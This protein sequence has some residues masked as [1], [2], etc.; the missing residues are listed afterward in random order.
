MKLFTVGPTQMR[1]EIMEVGG[2]MV[3]Y[4]RTQEFSNL[5]L[6]SDRLVQKFMHAP[7]GS[8]GIYLTASGTGAMEAVIMNCLTKEDKVLVIDG[9]TFG[10][11]FA[12]LC[13]I[14]EIPYECVHLKADEQLTEDKLAPFDNIG[15]TALLV[16]IDETS[17]GQLYD[18]NMLANFCRRNHCYF[19]VDA[20]SSY[21]IDPFNMEKNGIDVVVVSSQ[22]GMCIAPGLS[23]VMLS[24]RIIEERVKKSKVQNLYFNFKEYLKNFQR[25]QTPFTPCVGICLE[26]NRALHLIDEEGETDFLNRIGEVAKDFRK[27]VQVLPVKIPKFPLSNAV[28][29]IIFDKPIAKKVFEVLKDQY[30][31]FVNPTGG[32]RENYV[33]RVAHIGDTTVEDNKMLIQVMDN[34]IKSILEEEE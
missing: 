8:K 10:H 3:P 29:P 20:I 34:V 33:L 17:T 28:T 31:I 27:R 13:A 30:D 1:K 15:F 11:R 14:H 9:G 6:D 24:P 4:F 19:I 2:Q 26:M 7:E 23:V 12:Q 32:A 21:L 5:M 22:K 18:V 16:N 25:G